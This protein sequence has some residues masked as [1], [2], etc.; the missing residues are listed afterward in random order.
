M[1]NSTDL[2]ALAKGYLAAIQARDLEACMSFFTNDSTVEGRDSRHDGLDS[3]RAW[4][5]SR[6]EANM[7]VRVESLKAERERVVADVVVTSDRLANTRLKSLPSRITFVF[8]G[9]KIKE[10]RMSPRMPNLLGL[11]RS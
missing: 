3:I 9:D 8:D 1:T 11:F 4:H 2:E 6:F 7:S 5:Q 10:A